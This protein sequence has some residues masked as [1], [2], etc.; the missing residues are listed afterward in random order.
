MINKIEITRLD[1][2]GECNKCK[3]VQTNLQVFSFPEGFVLENKKT[4]KE[5]HGRLLCHQCLGD[6]VGKELI[7]D[8]LNTSVGELFEENKHLSKESRM[9]MEFEEYLANADISELKNGIF[10]KWLKKNNYPATLNNIALITKIYTKY[11]TN[12][13][14]I[15]FGGI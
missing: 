9:C 13:F 11:V 2:Y 10:E 4:H 15:A 6:V 1:S 7:T 14:K 5:L 12:S 3:K 8:H